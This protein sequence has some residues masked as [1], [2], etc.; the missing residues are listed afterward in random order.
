M[1]NKNLNNY[2]IRYQKFKIILCTNNPYSYSG[3]L[4]TNFFDIAA[5]NLQKAEKTK[6]KEM[7]SKTLF[8]P[9]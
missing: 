3:I 4:M 8:W 1:Y 2:N 6:M 9:R 5:S 7:T